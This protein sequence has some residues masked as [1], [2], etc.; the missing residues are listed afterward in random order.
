MVHRSRVLSAIALALLIVFGAL[1][2]AARDAG[3]AEARAI[4]TEFPQPVQNAENF[5]SA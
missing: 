2:L 5:D 1:A 4:T 3:Q